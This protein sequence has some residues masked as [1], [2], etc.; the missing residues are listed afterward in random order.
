MLVIA[1]SLD[2]HRVEIHLPQPLKSPFL[3]VEHRL[4]QLGESGVDQAVER[5]YEADHAAVEGNAVAPAHVEDMPAHVGEAAYEVIV[6]QRH[7]V[8]V[9]VDQRIPAAVPG[10]LEAHEGVH[11]MDFAAQHLANLRG[12]QHVGVGEVTEKTR[13]L[14]PHDLAN[15]AVH[16]Q[17]GIVQLGQVQQQAQPSGPAVAGIVDTA[18]HTVGNGRV[19][20]DSERCFEQAALVA[21]GA[22]GH[23]PSPWA[24]AG[25]DR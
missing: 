18:Q 10:S 21:G 5:V 7:D 19:G 12:T 2:V 9:G 20:G 24:R 17:R 22:S 11:T 1:A 15:Q 16:Q 13:V 14:H 25:R 23:C 4:V 6:Q 3:L 8:E